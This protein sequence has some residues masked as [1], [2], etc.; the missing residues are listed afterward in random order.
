VTARPPAATPDSLLRQALCSNARLTVGI[1]TD[2]G[3]CFAAPDSVPRSV[4][5]LHS[6]VPCGQ[7]QM[8]WP[9][10]D[11]GYPADIV[12]SYQNYSIGASEGQHRNSAVA[13]HGIQEKTE[14]GGYILLVG[15]GRGL[16]I[17]AETAGPCINAGLP[18]VTADCPLCR[19]PLQRQWSPL[20]VIAVCAGR[21]AAP[22]D[23]C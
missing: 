13:A 16:R 15:W 18:A 10:S 11:C 8:S 4:I 7:S 6:R 9:W 22:G 23:V 14:L 19:Y 3:L 17:S 12:V 20:I 1:E 2:S 5:L 21:A